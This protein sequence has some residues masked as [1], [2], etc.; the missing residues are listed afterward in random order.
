MNSHLLAAGEEGQL[1]AAYA[2]NENFSAQS[3]YLSD[4]SLTNV[5][6]EQKSYCI[7]NL[8][9]LEMYMQVAVR[10]AQDLVDRTIAL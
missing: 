8:P 3:T 6:V 5:N 4:V 10:H 1:H 2:S 9:G 7:G